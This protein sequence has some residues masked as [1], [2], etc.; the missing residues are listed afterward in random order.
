MYT[1]IQND[2]MPTRK[3]RVGERDVERKEKEQARVCVRS[4]NPT[5]LTSTNF[6]NLY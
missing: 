3:N 5:R 6:R 1:H 2:D 4:A